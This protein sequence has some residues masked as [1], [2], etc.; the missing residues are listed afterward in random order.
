MK[1]FSF[2]IILALSTVCFVTATSVSDFEYEI[3]ENQ[4]TI[5][6]YLG[7]DEEVVIPDKIE[8]YPVTVLEDY[9]FSTNGVL[10]SVVLPSDLLT[11]GT[12]CFYQCTNLMNIEI[13]DK[14]T[15]I[16]RYAFGGCIRLQ[17]INIPAGV[18]EIGERAFVNSSATI[19]VDES[20]ASYCSEGGVLFNKDKS[21]LIF[22]PPFSSATQYV[23]PEDVSRIEAFAFSFCS[24]LKTIVLPKNM[25]GIQYSAFYLCSGLEYIN[26]HENIETI[27]AFAFSDCARLTN[28]VMSSV[29]EIED[30]AFNKCTALEQIDLGDK[31]QE[32]RG[33]SFRECLS[34]KELTFPMTFR[35][36]APTF[37]DCPSLEHLYFKG[38]TPSTSFIWDTQV[39][40]VFA[41]PYP[42]IHYLK[43][44]RGWKGEYKVDTE[45]NQF[46]PQE[47]SNLLRFSNWWLEEVN[48][49]P[50]TL[51]ANEPEVFVS[52]RTVKDGKV[53]MT[54][55]F[56]GALQS[57]TNL[58]DWE[59]VETA[60][61]YLVSVP[62]GGEKFYRAV[63][64]E[65]VE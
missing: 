16:G 5:I 27:G 59:P 7:T 39:S 32:I 6:T 9:S 38:N 15:T 54:L 17:T 62:T 34:L 57:S 49:H 51:P 23:I 45:G 61:P 36:F 30:L 64:S 60:S 24:N 10:K 18:E 22:Y 25:S 11:I 50:W 53:E 47:T 1:Y 52:Q 21:T 63:S 29:I 37:I 43:G 56:G 26:L 40:D 3:A 42:T 44:T 13:P 55:V 20:N 58:K 12:R 48:V 41:A 31:L 33:G 8:E 4:V 2:P 28:V 46:D 65:V 14:V 19:Q 35:Y